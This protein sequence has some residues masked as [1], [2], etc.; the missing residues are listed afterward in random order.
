MTLRPGGVLMHHVA[1]LL[2]LGSVCACSGAGSSSRPLSI[3]S[4]NLDSGI[5]GAGGDGL[6]SEEVVGRPTGG[7]VLSIPVR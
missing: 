6:G 7:G 3:Y 1:V 2:L 5:A 4:P